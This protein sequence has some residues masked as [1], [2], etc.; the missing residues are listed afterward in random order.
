MWVEGGLGE[1]ATGQ[2]DGKGKERRSW[3]CVGVC[4]VCRM[5]GWCQA[6]VSVRRSP[7]RAAQPRPAQERASGGGVVASPSSERTNAPARPGRSGNEARPKGHRS[8]T[9]CHCSRHR[10]AYRESSTH[11]QDCCVRTGI[12]TY[13]YLH[14]LLAMSQSVRRRDAHAAAPNSIH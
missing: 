4:V 1:K 2:G 13:L 14:I 5:G 3:A 7:Q 9:L 6:Q 12:Y 11:V 8:A 10:V